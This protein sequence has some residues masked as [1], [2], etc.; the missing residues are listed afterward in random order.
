MSTTTATITTTGHPGGA[1]IAFIGIHPQGATGPT[2]PYGQLL[3]DVGTPQLLQFT[4]PATAVTQFSSQIPV[5]LS[6]L[7]RTFASQG[8]I[9]G[10]RIRLTNAVDFKIGW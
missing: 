6:M 10:R 5:N 1:S 2:I 8:V 7:G 9:A 4:Q 3:V